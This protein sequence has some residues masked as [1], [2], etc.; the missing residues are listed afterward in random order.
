MH[1]R[2]TQPPLSFLF[3][4]ILFLLRATAIFLIIF[5][6]LEPVL[7]LNSRKENAPVNVVFVDNSSSIAAAGKGDQSA[8]ITAF[9]RSL[10]DAL[11]DNTVFASFGIDIKEIEN[12]E[13]FTPDFSS[14]LTNLYNIITKLK[15]DKRNVVSAV[16]IS[17]GI[18]TDGSNPVYQAAK[19]GIPIFTVAVGDSADQKDLRIT[20]VSHNDLIYAGRA[21]VLSVDIANDGIENANPVISFFEEGKFL[22]SRPVIFPKDSRQNLEFVYT[23]TGSGEKRLDFKMESVSGEISAE[24]NKKQVFIRVRESRIRIAL[25]A[26]A[27]SA[28]LRFLYQALNSDADFEVKR[29]IEISGSKSLD[30]GLSAVKPDSSDVFV[31][32]GFPGY[33]TSDDRIRRL[34]SALSERKKPVLF[35]VNRDTDLK[36]LVRFNEVLPFS[37]GVSNEVTEFQPW[38]ADSRSSVVNYQALNSFRFDEL[39]PVFYP[40][41]KALPKPGSVTLLKASIRNV[42]TDKPVYISRDIYNSRSLALLASDTW[43]WKLQNNSKIEGFYDNFVSAAIRWLHAAGN[44][45][46]IYVKPVKKSFISGEETQFVAQVFD[47]GL[48]PV[49]NADVSVTINPDN[50]PTSLPLI[51]EGS[52]FYKISFGQL[53]PGNYSYTGLVD[54]KG[55]GLNY[56]AK[57]SFVVGAI[58]P[59]KIDLKLNRT[60]L[61]SLSGETG[62]DYFS[63]AN[64][65]EL[66]DR[67]VK[68]T[69]SSSAEKI[70]ASE[71]DLRTNFL[72]L[73]IPLILL[74]IEWMLRKTFGLL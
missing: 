39:P 72:L 54:F 20:A 19:A 17:D 36:K 28:D 14:S 41:I 1:Y 12:P 52:G 71:F 57:G 38:L 37:F 10:N 48:N 24:N 26:G 35:F 27:P 46:N 34:V 67:L 30:E 25:Y 33:T 56:S 59:E 15:S 8:A 47:D 32:C 68:I 74:A 31:L 53:P 55:S 6:L 65:Q 63:L 70:I 43:K 40:G 49:E 13:D 50:N 42:P 22:E 60:L 62:G 69:R 44:R 7:R 21:S 23:P 51:P 61:Y 4:S 3:R 2:R 11:P 16:I 29:F 9:L 66:I 45:D 18:I 73:L 64:S 5:I 58:D